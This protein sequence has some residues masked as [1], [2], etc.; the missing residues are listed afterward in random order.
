MVLLNKMRPLQNNVVEIIEL[1]NLLNF[2]ILPAEDYT[3]NQNSAQ[4][5][6]NFVF[7]NLT[8]I[9]HS[10]ILSGCQGDYKF[11]FPLKRRTQY[12]SCDELV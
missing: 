5:K 2:M 11:S 9:I 12:E 7:V 4:N 6:F 1:P 3:L 8:N 10:I